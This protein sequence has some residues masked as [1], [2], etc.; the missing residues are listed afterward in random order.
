MSS[1]EA[2]EEGDF[3]R[4]ADVKSNAFQSP[5]TMTERVQLPIQRKR[6]IRVQVNERRTKL[7]EVVIETSW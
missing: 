2:F 5:G 4:N 7:E 3:K 1:R 6:E